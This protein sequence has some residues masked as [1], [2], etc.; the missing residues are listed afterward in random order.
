MNEELD[1]ALHEDDI[2]RYK[3]HLTCDR[4]VGSWTVRLNGHYI[5]D[6]WSE[7]KARRLTMKLSAALESLS[8][9]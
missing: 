3:A 7:A 5:W 9:S 1:D 6:T 8:T 2:R 4:E